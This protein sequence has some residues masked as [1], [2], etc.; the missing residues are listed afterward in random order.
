MLQLSKCFCGLI[1]AAR[2]CVPAMSG[3]W[4]KETVASSTKVLE[5][6]VL[7]WCQLHE[8]RREKRIAST[9]QILKINV[10]NNFNDIIFMK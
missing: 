3:G 9:E 2:K 7:W 8:L 10:M 6:V 4:T 5:L 1:E